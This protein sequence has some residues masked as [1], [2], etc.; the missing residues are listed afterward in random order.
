MFISPFWFSSHD[1]LDVKLD[2]SNNNKI[3][4]QNGLHTKSF[5]LK[6][7]HGL[8]LVIM[9][10]SSIIFINIF[11]NV[12]LSIIMHNIG[13]FQLYMHGFSHYDY[14]CTWSH[15]LCDTTTPETKKTDCWNTNENVSFQNQEIYSLKHQ[16]KN[17]FV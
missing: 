15:R 8:H 13:H 6:E 3:T 11:I 10:I 2:N 12:L 1:H 7:A 16:K 14:T 9:I 17:N 5:N 4:V